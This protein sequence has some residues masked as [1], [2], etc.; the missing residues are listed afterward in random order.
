[1]RVMHRDGLGSLSVAADAAGLVSRSGTA[2][3]AELAARVGL[4]LGASSALLH[5]TRRQPMH[6]PGRVVCDLAAML[7]D[8][9]DCVSDLG[10]LADQPDLF[11][12]VASRST[13][14]RLLHALGGA[15][16]RRVASGALAGA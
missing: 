14:S 1:M 2:L 9:G 4:A 13:A 12:E 8:G 6:A 5:L 10:A 7:I 3:V 11:G 16:A 15:G